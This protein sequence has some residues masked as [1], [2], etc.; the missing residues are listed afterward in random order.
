M[1]FSDIPFAREEC[2]KYCD[3]LCEGM[4]ECNGKF[5][6]GANSLFII[7]FGVLSLLI[8]TIILLQI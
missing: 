5:C 3:F 4:A 1:P 8:G 2:R 6:I 7:V